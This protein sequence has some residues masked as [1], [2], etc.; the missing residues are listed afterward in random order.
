MSQAKHS[1]RQR[2][3]QTGG[4]QKLK[5][6]RG[7][8]TIQRD[9][10][11]IPTIRATC[12]PDLFFAQGFVHAQDRLWQMELNRRAAHGTLAAML[13]PLALDTDRLS[14][15]LGFTRLAQEGTPHIYADIQ[16]N[17]N[18]YTAGVNAYLNG[19]FPRPLEFTLL[20]HQPAPWTVLDSVAFGYLQ[21]WALSFGW[22]SEL[23]RAQ[24]IEKVGPEKAAELEPLYPERHP[25]TLPDGLELNQLQVDKMIAAAA[26]PFLTRA[27]EA[28]GRGS[29]GWV[30][31]PWKSSTGQA[32]LCNDMHLPVRTPALWYFNH[33]LSDDG[34]HVTGVS[35]PGLPYVLVGHN[36]HI[37]WGATLAFTDVE[38]LFIE[39]LHPHDPTR[40]R[41]GNGWRKIKAIAEEIQVRGRDSHHEIVRLTHHGPLISPVLGNFHP[42]AEQVALSLNSMALRPDPIFNGFARLNTA[43]NWAEFVEA[44]DEMTAPPLNLLYADSAGNIGHYVSGRVPIRAQ[45]QGIVPAPGWTSEHEW[46]GEIPFAE[47]P[48]S[49]N[50]ARGYIISA[51]HRLIGTE[52]PYYLGSQWVNGYRAARLEQLFARHERISPDDCRQFQMDWLS[53]PGLELKEKLQRKLGLTEKRNFSLPADAQLALDILHR[54]GG[55]MGPDQAGPAVYTVFMQRFTRLL[56]HNELGEALFNRLVGAGPNEFFA[57][58]NEFYGRLTPVLLDL[59]DKPDS[60]WLSV[61]QQD[62][63]LIQAL[64]ET[65]QTL[66]H[67]LGQDTRQWRWGQLHGVRFNHALGAVRPLNRLFSQGPF[68]VGGD[69]D[70]VNQTAMRVDRPYETN[71]QAVSYRQ[72]VQ[73]GNWGQSV[74]MYAPGQSGSWSSEHYGDMIDAWLHG[75]YFVMN[76]HIAEVAAATCEELTLLASQPG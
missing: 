54:W 22:A 36:D 2:R 4:Q 24:L 75:A 21:A 38:D 69:T 16:A 42:A 47:M 66:R 73:P 39:K 43:Q 29:N 10:W 61:I 3:T 9:Q 37:T 20:R 25:V 33:L 15:T 70:T 6:L 48:H 5:G 14:R 64:A 7:R 51:N 8:V 46:I 11:G 67:L 30:I 17:L 34:F 65:T 49:F 18:A 71:A 68:P 59:L 72:I 76:W 60:L 28:D 44:V 32:I 41:F 19:P 53:L 63:L 50:P 23:V 35:Q 13:G 57:P 45:G 74:A 40:Y 52:Y 26:G 62:R 12:Q 58:T 56:L 1:G 27:P 31:A 55:W